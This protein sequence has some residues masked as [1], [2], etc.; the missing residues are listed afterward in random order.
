[1]KLQKSTITDLC[2]SPKYFLSFFHYNFFQIF[3]P[4]INNSLFWKVLWWPN[5]IFEMEI[6]LTCTQQPSRSIQWECCSSWPFSWMDAW[7]EQ[8]LLVSAITPS[9]HLQLLTQTFSG[10]LL[11]HISTNSLNERDHCEPVNWG[12]GFFGIRNS[13]CNYENFKK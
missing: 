10:S 13:T 5:T 9:L 6:I 12:G 8:K 4:S 7:A 2:Y 11:R 1:M 3:S